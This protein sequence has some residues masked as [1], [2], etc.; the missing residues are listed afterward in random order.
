MH[1]IPLYIKTEYSL[2]D[3]TIKVKEL[4]EFALKNNLKGYLTHAA[5]V[6]LDTWKLVNNN[7]NIVAQIIKQIQLLQIVVIQVQVVKLQQAIQ[8]IK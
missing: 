8:K 6:N 3:S 1:Y 7:D 4:V 2:L 5:R